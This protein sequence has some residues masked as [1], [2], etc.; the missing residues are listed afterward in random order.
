MNVMIGHQTH[1]P[2]PKERGDYNAHD[3]AFFDAENVAFVLMLWI[4]NIHHNSKEKNL[5]NSYHRGELYGQ[6]ISLC[7]YTISTNV[8]SPSTSAL[9]DLRVRI[10]CIMFSPKKMNEQTS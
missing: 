5:E 3:R 10:R 2:N 8:E 6:I 4:V 7:K 9:F 1:S